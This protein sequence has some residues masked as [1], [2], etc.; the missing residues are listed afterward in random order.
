MTIW[1]FYYERKISGVN[2]SKE[3]VEILMFKAIRDN[4][5]T[6]RRVKVFQVKK[7]SYQLKRQNNQ[8]I[9]NVETV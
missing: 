5:I 6:V 9:E 8:G 3:I 2:F 7:M 1:N 4:M